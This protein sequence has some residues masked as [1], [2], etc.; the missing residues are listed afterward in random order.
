MAGEVK[1]CGDSRFAMDFA[2]VGDTIMY[3]MRNHKL[4]TSAVKVLLY[5]LRNRDVDT[6][7][8][9]G[10]HVREIAEFWTI[11][12]KSVRRALADLT[13]AG[14]Y[15]P[16]NRGGDIITGTLFPNKRYSELSEGG[17]PDD[18]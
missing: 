1:P 13:D 16:P 8:L 10:T 7:I 17:K 18:T 4:N 14:L 11:S 3:K 6:G 15:E 5:L 2:M 12:T 9:H